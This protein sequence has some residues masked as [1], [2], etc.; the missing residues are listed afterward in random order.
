MIFRR[1]G[2]GLANSARRLVGRIAVGLWLAQAEPVLYEGPAQNCALATPLLIIH[3]AHPF[4]FGRR[5]AIVPLCGR[6]PHC[7]NSVPGITRK[8]RSIFRLRYSRRQWHLRVGMTGMG[9]LIFALP[10]CP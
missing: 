9:S 5:S 8:S 2:L 7:C 4:C 3:G 1:D 6:T 10:R